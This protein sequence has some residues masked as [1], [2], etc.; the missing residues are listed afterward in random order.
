MLLPALAKECPCPACEAQTAA[1]KGNLPCPS[2]CTVA[3]PI[4]AVGCGCAGTESVGFGYAPFNSSN[5]M[6]SRSRQTGQA[7]RGLRQR[8]AQ[9]RRQLINA[10]NAIQ[11][12]Q[13][14][15]QQGGGYQGGYAQQDDGS[16]YDGDSDDMGALASVAGSL[17]CLG[18]EL[19]TLGAVAK[20]GKISTAKG[21]K[22]AL[23]ALDATKQGLA[24]TRDTLEENRTRNYQAQGQAA[25]LRLSVDN[26]RRQADDLDEQLATLPEGDDVGWAKKML[27]YE[28]SIT[29]AA[30]TTEV[31]KTTAELDKTKAGVEKLDAGA[32][33]AVKVS[34]DVQGLLDQVAG[35]T[36]RLY[37]AFSAGGGAALDTVTPGAGQDIKRGADRIK[38]GVDAARRHIDEINDDPSPSDDE[39][40]GQRGAATMTS[41]IENVGEG[42]DLGYIPNPPLQVRRAKFV[43]YVLGSA[44]RVPQIHVNIR[45]NATIDQNLQQ[46]LGNYYYNSVLSWANTAAQ[47]ANTWKRAAAALARVRAKLRSVNAQLIACGQQ[48]MPADFGYVPTADYTPADDSDDFSDAGDDG[49]GGGGDSGGDDMGKVFGADAVGRGDDGLGNEDV[50]AMTP[51]QRKELAERKALRREGAAL[52]HEQ[53]V[54][55]R[56]G[57]A[58]HHEH[59]VATAEA[60]KIQALRREL[61]QVKHQLAECQKQLGHHPHGHPHHAK[62]KQHE[63][64]LNGLVAALEAN[65]RAYEMLNHEL[66]REA[67]GKGYDGVSGQ[68]APANGTSG[69][70]GIQGI[71]G[72]PAPPQNSGIA[73]IQGTQGGKDGVGYYPGGLGYSYH[74]SGIVGDGDLGRGGGGGGGGGFGGGGH[75]GFGGH[76]GGAYA[77]GW[78]SG[79]SWSQPS[80]GGGYSMFG[81]LAWPADGGGDDLG[82]RRG[83]GLHNHAPGFNAACRTCGPQPQA[84]P[85]TGGLAGYGSPSGRGDG[86][87]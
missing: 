15:L 13:Q 38:R 49:G 80:Q 2:G 66:V 65:I 51:L 6:L 39:A 10:R 69:T 87:N 52:H 70:Q 85:M 22:D 30:A 79:S 48:P 7:Q 50:G 29:K 68:G 84:G 61:G 33:A 45:G 86:T 59:G 42:G 4:E 73:G 81:N 77:G 56:E 63:Q 62:H 41:E 25:K 60:R 20:A 43:R 74:P 27:G 16:T 24:E 67:E 44:P 12:L 37:R 36:D 54:A 64:H 19:E 78:G 55:H 21:A 82:G 47:T 17:G 57:A 71:Q 1:G 40:L 83:G 14:Q 46:A 5:N 11:Q 9:C 28:V 31:A 32:K 76:G 26:Q 35:L 53:S 72:P 3:G 34:G 18:A 8:V 75:G 23:D 58:L